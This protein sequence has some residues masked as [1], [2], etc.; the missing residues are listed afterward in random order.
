MPDQSEARVLIIGREADVLIRDLQ[1]STIGSTLHWAAA[2]GIGDAEATWALNDFDV[3]VIGDDLFDSSSAGVVGQVREAAPESAIV[4]LT[5]HDPDS[6]D[7]VRVDLGGTG[8]HK[9]APPPAVFRLRDLPLGERLADGIA[10]TLRVH[11]AA[12]AQ[13]KLL[14]HISDTVTLIDSEA[15][16]MNTT[17]QMMEVLG[18]T[19]NYWKGRS[20]FDLCHPDEREAAAMT[21]ADVLASPNT[22]ISAEFRAQHEDGHWE[23]LEFTAVN[24]L[25]DPSVGAIVLTTRNVTDRV[26]AK[27]ELAIERDQAMARSA[28]KSEFVAGVV[29][30]FRSP[31][32]IVLGLTELLQSAGL[33]EESDALVGRIRSEAR[34]LQRVLDD[35]LDIS[36]IEARRMFLRPMPFSVGDIVTDVITT[37]RLIAAD[38]GVTITNTIDLGSD[39][40]RVGDP[41]R[42]RQVLL[43]LVGN[44]VK[45]TESGRVEVA[46]FDHE[47][48]HETVAIEVSDTGIGIPP[49][50]VATVFDPFSA[51]SATTSHIYGGS[52]LGLSISQQLVQLMGGADLT[53]SSMVGHGSKFSFAV[54]LP[55]SIGE[56]SQPSARFTD[57]DGPTGFR[58]LV[59]ED[60]LVNQQ[61]V[62]LQL[63]A[64]GHVVTIVGSAEEALET[65]FSSDYDAVLMDCELP[66]MDGVEATR[67]IRRREL[68]SDRRIPI[69]AVTASAM[70][71]HK[72]RCLAAGMD[73]F[74]AKPVGLAELARVLERWVVPEQAVAQQ[75]IDEGEDTG[76]AS[77]PVLD[78]AHLIELAQDV[79]GIDALRKTIETYLRELPGRL[80]AVRQAADDADEPTLRRRAHQ[81]RSPS[82]MLGAMAIADLCRLI[83]EGP[84]P[85]E[86]ADP[87]ILATSAGL[88]GSAMREFLSGA[89][90]P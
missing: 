77:V 58:V 85:I 36:Q 68:G 81:L 23:N 34:R 46:V 10:Q 65:V 16:M 84:D 14:V 5:K 76:P 78:Q 61:L 66:G 83:E 79:G 4:V 22:E 35:I 20:A 3:V 57:R 86:A 17:G 9:L 26:L 55:I 64:I 50:L 15:R 29:H 27:M 19:R 59:V 63:D 72:A 45:F 12:T 6:D 48:Q 52:G 28:A 37:Y 33:E 42:F 40:E 49:D 87:A 67:R 47:D 11:R 80:N 56:E 38:K 32:H 62:R 7:A 8:A 54:P 90:R 43:N 24:L 1:T 41:D 82:V 53:V 44:A 2:S 51:A 73:D 18:R 30:E 69:I 70:A 25:D 21:F 60:N 74:V 75:W 88:T 71:D 13:R 89:K 39:T 31:L